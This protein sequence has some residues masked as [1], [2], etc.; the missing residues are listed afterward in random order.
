MPT[1]PDDEKPAYFSI[2]G[3]NFVFKCPRNWESLEQTDKEDKRHCFHCDRDVH[4][5]DNAML[6]KLH[7]KA[8]HCVALPDPTRQLIARAGH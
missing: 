5:V 7:A 1:F 6:F 3:C 4:R 8:G 2:E